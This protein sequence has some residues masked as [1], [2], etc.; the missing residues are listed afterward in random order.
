MRTQD[1]ESV[2]ARSHTG[3]PPRRDARGGAGRGPLGL[4]LAAGLLAA[5]PVTS[6]CGWDEDL[7]IHNFKGTVVLPVEAATRTFLRIDEDGNRSEETVTD[8]RLIGPVY[9]GLFPSVEPENVIASY[10][11]PEI[12]PQYKAGVQGDTYPYGGSTVGDLQYACFEFLQC[13]VTTGRYA[14]WDDLA[15]WFADVLGTPIVDAAGREIR[16]GELLRQTCFDLLEV[17]ADYEIGVVA[18]DR[19]DDGN[20]DEADLDFVLSDDGQFYVAEFTIWQQEYFWDQAQEGCTPGVDCRGFSLWGWMDAPDRV[21]HQFSTCEATRGYNEL[22]YDRN[23][24]GGATF[25]DV[26]NQPTQYISRGDWVASEGYVWEDLYAQ[27]ELKLD[28][29]VT[30]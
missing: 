18:G 20:V 3:R 16:N 6:G 19:N 28:F 29:E 24:R 27:P 12:G 21:S 14:S 13:K 5:L 11:H 1:T 23:F 8:P 9:L 15:T 22:T 25:R 4:A 30:Q 17:T 26:L 10:P 7:L 2:R